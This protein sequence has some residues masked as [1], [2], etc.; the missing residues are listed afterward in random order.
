MRRTFLDTRVLS[1]PGWWH[2]TIT[3]PVVAAHLLGVPWAIAAAMFLSAAMALYYFLRLRR[4]RP[5]PVQLRLAFL[6]VLLI[7][8]LPA[9]FWLYYVALVGMTVRVTVGY[10]LLSRL[11]GLA[12]FNRSEPLTFSL[13]RRQFLSPPSGGLLRWRRTPEVDVV[14]SCSLQSRRLP[15]MACTIGRSAVNSCSIDGDCAA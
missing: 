14:E 5:F 8:L 2:W 7:G 6:G 1:D 4:V 11:L 9:M 15:G 13:L 12:W 3:I 10:C